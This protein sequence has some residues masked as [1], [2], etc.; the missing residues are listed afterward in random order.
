MADVKRDVTLLPPQFVAH[1]VRH[2]GGIYNRH[3][4]DGFSFADVDSAMEAATVV[5]LNAGFLIPK[6]SAISLAM[7]E[8]AR[9]PVWLNV[10]LSRPGLSQSTQLHT[11]KQDVLLVQTT[12]RKRWR[13][14]RRAL[15]SS[16][17]EQ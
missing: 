10:Y 16:W 3:V 9:L 4:A 1:G 17:G 14:Y 6:L 13:V 2:A 7:V 12:G 8:A 11:D 15:Q 5:L